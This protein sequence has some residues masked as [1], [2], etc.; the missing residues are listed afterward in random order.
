VDRRVVERRFDWNNCLVACVG[1]DVCSLSG[2]NMGRVALVV[3]DDPAVLEVIANMLED[4]GYDV[5]CASNGADALAILATDK[6][7]EILITDINMPG[8]AGY[9]L[10]EKAKRVRPGVN[11]IL[12]SGRESDSHG[13]PMIR[14]PFFQD[15]LRRV[16]KETTGLC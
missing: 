8:I 12:L 11:P 10:A 2:S 7:I 5:S 15:D 1:E 16:M 4:L 13:F 6:R 3:D 9:E 14:K